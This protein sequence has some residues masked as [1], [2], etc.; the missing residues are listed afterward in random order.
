MRNY[1]S[2]ILFVVVAV[3]VYLYNGQDSGQILA[4]PFIDVIVPS[5]KGDP[6]AMGAASVKLML[7]VGGALLAFGAFRHIRSRQE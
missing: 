5:T 4:F 3:G 2:G 7:G 6:V 1:L